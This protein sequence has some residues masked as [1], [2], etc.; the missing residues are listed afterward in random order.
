MH[1]RY[2]ASGDRF[3]AMESSEFTGIRRPD[4]LRGSELPG[5]ITRIKTGESFLR[6][7][8][9]ARGMCWQFEQVDVSRNFS[10][11]F[12]VERL[13][14]C[15]YRIKPDLRG[16]GLGYCGNCLRK[17]VKR[18]IKR[19]NCEMINYSNW[20]GT[21]KENSTPLRNQ[22]IPTFAPNHYCFSLRSTIKCKQIFKIKKLR[23]EIRSSYTRLIFNREGTRIRIIRNDMRKVR[24]VRW[25]KG[26]IW[27]ITFCIY[28]GNQTSMVQKDSVILLASSERRLEAAWWSINLR[29][30]YLYD[31]RVVTESLHN[32]Q[33]CDSS[34]LC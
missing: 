1:T 12:Y 23:K 11:E 26:L 28:R 18:Q 10:E 21:A 30:T 25:R 27:N 34:C 32:A 24:L 6:S 3:S 4:T 31:N 8:H 33:L 22:G 9:V 15:C 5:S 13:P 16:R 14:Y 2:C 7:M 19:K 29:I 20:K 17:S